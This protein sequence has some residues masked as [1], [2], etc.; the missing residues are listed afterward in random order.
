[1]T[2]QQIRSNIHVFNFHNDPSGAVIRYMWGDE[3]T[4]IVLSAELLQQDL[5]YIGSIEDDEDISNYQL[6]QWDA[7]NLACRAEMARQIQADAN[8]MAIDK[9][10]K[11]INNSTY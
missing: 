3:V 4:S 5:C 1:M 7:L 2:T 6:S 11:S 9:A 8:I 10:I